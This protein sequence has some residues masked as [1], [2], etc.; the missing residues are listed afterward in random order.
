MSRFPAGLVR[1]WW[2]MRQSLCK[3]KGWSRIKNGNLLVLAANE[4]DVLLTS[5]RAWSTSRT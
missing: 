3:G 5:D 1:F 4:F 2:G